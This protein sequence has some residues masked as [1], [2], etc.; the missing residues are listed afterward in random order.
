M[1]KVLRNKKTAKKIWL[2]LIILIL[3]G[4]LL[5][6][7]GSVA[8]DKRTTGSAGKI[9]GRNISVLEYRDAMD[10]IRVQAVMQFGDK[11]P[12][13]EKYLNPPAQAWERL[14]LLSEAK[15]R[16]IN[17]SD[18]EVE[19]LIASYPFFQNERTGF[20]L[21]RY[22]EILQYVF[23]VQARAFEE[24]TRQNLILSKLF[25]EISKSVELNDKEIAEEYRK[26]NEDISIYYVAGLSADFAK[27]INPS[28]EELKAY[29]KEKSAEFKQPLSFNLE[30]VAIPGESKDEE[31]VKAKIK[32]IMGRLN[33]TEA[34]SKVAAEF[35]LSVK[36][37]GL[38]AETDPIPGIGWSPQIS[39][40]IFKAKVG[41]YLPPLFS[42]K[43][44]YLL[45]LKDRKEPYVPE[46][47]SIKTKVKEAYV[48]EK[49]QNIAKAKTED[50][51]KQLKDAY[52]LNPKEVDFDKAAKPYGL[53]SSSTALFKFGSY[54]EGIGA[55]DIFWLYGAN[56]NDN[57]PSE[58]ITT[59]A[60][61]Y[62]AKR[63]SR[64]AIDEAKFAKEKEEFSKKTLLQKKEEHFAKFAQELK[65]KAQRY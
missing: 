19:Q 23:R 12:E 51:L 62:I 1:L 57:Q 36:E 7:L 3:P 18:K 17:A 5:W 13:M 28:D 33:K 26:A 14:I 41:D 8:K 31:A 24:Q 27:D 55:S 32:T 42:D 50:C 38:F 44:Y 45:K 21:N 11:Y 4:F 47:E 63:K 39:I 60:G 34:F 6:G 40:M 59:A 20:D 52:L 49:S 54:I 58:L 29:F 61:Y 30:Y 43:S 16:G 64:V 9:F 25:E 37:T 56:L 2:V 48:K 53:K 46:F 10:A 65:E 15:K 22:N 35:N